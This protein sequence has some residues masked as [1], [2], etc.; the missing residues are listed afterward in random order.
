MSFISYWS[1]GKYDTMFSPAEPC[2]ALFGNWN[3]Y[4]YIVPAGQ[5]AH[6]PQYVAAIADDR[7][8]ASANMS[9]GPCLQTSS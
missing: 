3:I 6:G 4:I 1:E 9:R 7:T 8:T 5:G 2:R